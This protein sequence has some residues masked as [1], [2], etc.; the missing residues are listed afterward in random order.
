MQIPGELRAAL[1]ACL[2]GVPRTTLAQRA[3]RMSSLYRD[4]SGSSVAVQDADDALAYAITRSPA[5]FGAVRNVLGRL[6]ERAPDFVP[7]TA[8]DLGAGAGAASWALADTWPSI[9]S[10][11]QADLNNPLLTLGRRLA[12]NAFS[13][14]LRSAQQ[15]S[16]DLTRDLNAAD[17]ELVLVSYM[18]AEL[19]EKQINAVLANAWRHCAVAL[20]I[21]EPG[22]PA[23]YERILQ[24]RRFILQ[25]DG[26]VLAPCP[27]ESACPVA[28]PD[29]CHFAQR[30][31]RSRDHRFLKGADLPYEDE[32]FSYV[33]GV[34]PAIFRTA[35]HAR[36]LARPDKEKSRI[37][38]KLC[39]LDG[40]ASTRQI[41]R[42]E[43]EAYKA[44]K[45]SEWGDEL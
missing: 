21:V 11:I 38:V 15:L 4:R 2:E 8:L 14:S 24:A 32:K 41:W 18:L 37:E 5:T 28:A 13:P 26:R 29:W 42:R 45:K 1:D 33:I 23:G 35:E 27:H 44:A 9:G 17:A 31:E 12:A 7:T 22:T 30:V 40:N 6:Q 25:H 36:I 3:E 19:A 10:I 16:E 34:R 39:Q 20:V 43:K